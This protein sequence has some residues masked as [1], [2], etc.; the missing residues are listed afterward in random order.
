MTLFDKLLPKVELGLTYKLDD[1]EVEFQTNP[2]NDG[3]SDSDTP[4]ISISYAS[5]LVEIPAT[6]LR[7]LVKLLAR[8]GENVDHVDP[9][10]L[11][12][13]AKV[14]QA[15]RDADDFLNEI[16]PGYSVGGRSPINLD[17]R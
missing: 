16:C 13:P 12:D 8:L 15:K 11:L 3:G 17:A 4:T 2:Y 14:E 7:T 5:D 9:V 10:L 1:I 6:K